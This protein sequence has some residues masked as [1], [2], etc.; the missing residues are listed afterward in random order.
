MN[1]LLN[2]YLKKESLF[3]SIAIALIANVT[4]SITLLETK[5]LPIMDEIHIVVS[6]VMLYI[7]IKEILRT[8]KHGK[9]G[10]LFFIGIAQLLP[11]AALMAHTYYEVRNIYVEWLYVG[12]NILYFVFVKP[13]SVFTTYFAEHFIVNEYTV[14]IFLLMVFVSIYIVTFAWFK[15]GGKSE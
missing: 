13:W 10:Y 6:V 4:V 11:Y 5:K 7:W 9:A 1:R 2:D 14:M 3:E 12:Y 8:A 15:R